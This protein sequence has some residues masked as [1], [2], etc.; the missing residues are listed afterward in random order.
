MKYT[1]QIFGC[2][3]AY[4]EILIVPQ[5]RRRHSFHTTCP[6]MDQFLLFGDS[7]TQQSSLTFGAALANAYI[8][9]LDVVNRGFSGYNSRQALRIL[10]HAVPSPKVARLR[11]MT[12]FFGANDA[13]LPNTPGGPQQ[14]VPL[15]EYRENLK[16]VLTHPNVLAHREVRLI[17]I[18]PPSL[19]ERMC[20]ESAKAADPTFP[21]VVTRKASTT[22]QYANAVKQI[23]QELDIPVVDIW[24]ALIRRAGGSTDE[25]SHPTGSIDRPRNETFQAF[26]SDGLHLTSSGYE[27]LYEEL[28]S[29]ITKIRPEQVPDRLPFVFPSWQ[30]EKAWLSY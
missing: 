29:V 25:V 19:D 24:G 12:V 18:T 6:T 15:A 8:R 23:G 1:R 17:L 26:F 3:E 16:S 9:R 13:R 4:D 20:L 5:R 14:H 2:E 21:D 30:D 27:V 10:P 28:M 11:F 22:A 7:I